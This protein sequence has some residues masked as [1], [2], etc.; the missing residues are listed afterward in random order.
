MLDIVYPASFLFIA[1]FLLQFEPSPQEE[2]LQHKDVKEIIAE[3]GWRG[4]MS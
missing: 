1:I 3:E 4:F 2:V